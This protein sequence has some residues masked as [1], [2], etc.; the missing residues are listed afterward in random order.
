MM[1][2]QQ[3]IRPTRL[4]FT[5]TL[6]GFGFALGG[7]IFRKLSNGWGDQGKSSGRFNG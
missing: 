6:L 4:I 7:V 2:S 5:A 1:Q 3:K